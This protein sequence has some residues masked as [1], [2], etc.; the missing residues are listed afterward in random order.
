M[1]LRRLDL[2]RYGKFTDYTIDFGEARQGKPDL[3]I[4]YGL[5]KAGK[6]TALSAYLDLLFGVEH[7]SRYGFLHAYPTMLVGGALE[8]GGAEHAL[9]RVKGKGNT[10]R[11]GRG[12]PVDEALLSVP[13]AGLTRETYRAMFSLDDQSLEDGGNAIIAS[14]GELG[15]ML[16]TASA[17]L[18]D[19]STILTRVREEAD[20]I[21][22]LRGRSTQIAELKRN[23]A[24]LKTQQEEID[25]RASAHAALLATKL[26]AE[27]AYAYAEAIQDQGRT[28]TRQDEI[29]RL[30]RAAPLA[31]AYQ[32]LQREIEP[33]GTGPVPP[34]EWEGQLPR[35]MIKN[36]EL[37][38]QIESTEAELVR[39][40]EQIAAL[41]IDERLLGLSDAIAGLGEGMARFSTAESDLPRRQ[42]SIAEDDAIISAILAGLGQTGHTAPETL[43]LPAP[44]VGTLRELIEARSGIEAKTG[45]ARRELRQAPETIERATAALANSGAEK[46]TGMALEGVN[47]ALGTLR[48][49]NHQARMRVAERALPAIERRYHALRDSLAP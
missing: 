16:F 5:N 43:V 38:T 7:N 40:D 6:S 17:G 8:F 12:Q 42:A 26:Q 15:E 44:V 11:D 31:D 48:R 14:K 47:A 3:H 27:A 29:G 49:S 37:H 39:L 32:R 22:K 9:T 35:L 4:V 30:L 1:R 45:T 28:K 34:P 21:H 46:S 33:F 19:L 23:L 25:T 36:A 2:T 18:A 41:V 10:L 24:A 13:L 20:D